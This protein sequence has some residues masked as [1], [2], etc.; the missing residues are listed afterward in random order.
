M[1][2]VNRNCPICTTAPTVVEIKASIRADELTF[3]DTK[4]LWMGFR[5]NSCFF[6]YYRCQECKLL[7][8]K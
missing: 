3:E 4:K 1:E 5:K 7:F 8:N 6:D 2:W